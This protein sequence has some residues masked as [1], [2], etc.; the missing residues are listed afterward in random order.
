MRGIEWRVVVSIWLVTHV[1]HFQSFAAGI[2]SEK[3]MFRP[4]IHEISDN[5]IE[6][7]FVPDANDVHGNAGVSTNTFRCL[8]EFRSNMG[9]YICAKHGR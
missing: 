5:R 7:L 8:Q 2:D 6:Q 1:E 4:E 3:I 9:I